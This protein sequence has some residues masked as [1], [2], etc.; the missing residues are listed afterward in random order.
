MVDVLGFV[1]VALSA[2]LVA[3]DMLE[4]ARLRAVRGSLGRLARKLVDPRRVYATVIADMSQE[5]R[6]KRKERAQ[7]AVEE[8][9]S[10]LDVDPV[11]ADDAPLQAS[12][13]L[14]LLNPYGGSA[15]TLAIVTVL[16]AAAVLAISL[17]FAWAGQQ[18]DLAGYRITGFYA[19]LIV[20]V[21][22]LVLGVLLF[23]TRGSRKL[24]AVL[25]ICFI[26]SLALNPL[27][28]I[29]GGAILLTLFAIF[30]AAPMAAGGVLL[31]PWGMA[32]GTGALRAT[33]G[34]LGPRKA[35]LVGLGL[36]LALWAL[37]LV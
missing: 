32:A 18:P 8:A 33:A 7:R 27:A 15:R 3:F 1:L 25:R 9:A 36:G 24:A 10:P 37:A 12:D 6:A 21:A 31:L 17:V 30:G 4:D 16:G 14:I 20:S 19:S 34:A 26:V 22:A 2:G 23:V 13:Y 28:L 35:A 5:A 29:G 11:P